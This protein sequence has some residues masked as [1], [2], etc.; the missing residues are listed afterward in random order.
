MHP[1][2]AV[3]FDFAGTLLVPEPR[4]EWVAAVLPSL[5]P[6]EVADLA[7][8]LDEAGRPGGPEPLVVPARWAAD[9]PHR[10]LSR[11]VHREVYEG[12]LSAVTDV[13]TTRR[14]YDRATSAAGFV[15]TLTPFPCSLRCTTEGCPL[16]S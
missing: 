14:L 16:R 5:S 13:E 10:D 7:R 6:A 12:L 2:K 9:Y 11:A 8:R 3:L 15:P 1:I 4:D